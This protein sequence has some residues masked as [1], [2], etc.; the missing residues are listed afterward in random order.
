M[1]GCAGG[2]SANEARRAVKKCKLYEPQPSSD[3]PNG[4]YNRKAGKQG[5]NRVASFAF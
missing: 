4:S 3:Y 1:P 5:S 2:F